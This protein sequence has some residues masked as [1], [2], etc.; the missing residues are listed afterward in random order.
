MSDRE[1]R[2]IVRKWIACSMEQMRMERGKGHCPH[3][4]IFG[5]DQDVSCFMQ[6]VN[7]LG[8]LDDNDDVLAR[9]GSS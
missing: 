4:T 6:T 8:E 7:A 2:E 9:A 1:F 5:G 3:T